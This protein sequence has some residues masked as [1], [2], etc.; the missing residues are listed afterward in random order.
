MSHADFSSVG[1]AASFGGASSSF[2]RVRNPKVQQYHKSRLEMTL[3]NYFS[4]RNMN[5]PKLLIP[6]QILKTPR[7]TAKQ[8]LEIPLPAL[9]HA[10]F[11]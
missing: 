11:F 5:L 10:L 3:N 1:A 7:H 2:S 4:V 6:L 8:D 9:R